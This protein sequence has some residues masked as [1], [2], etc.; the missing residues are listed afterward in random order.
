M[1]TSRTRRPAAFS[2]LTAVAARATSEPVAM[3]M[4]SGPPAG[5]ISV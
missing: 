4:A 1:D 5:S 2:A 3:T